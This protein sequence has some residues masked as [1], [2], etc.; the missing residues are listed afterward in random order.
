MPGTRTGPQLSINAAAFIPP[1]TDLIIGHWISAK[2]LLN[3]LHTRP[4]IADNAAQHTAAVM[5][6]GALHLSI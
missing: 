3:F 5:P 1:M 4:G 6:N 2:T